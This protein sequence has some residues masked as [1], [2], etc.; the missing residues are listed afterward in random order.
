MAIRHVTDQPT[1]TQFSLVAVVGMCAAR[2][3]PP[4][5]PEIMS[6]LSKPFPIPILLV[7]VLLE[8]LEDRLA[9]WL[10]E[11]TG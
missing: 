1:E 2:G 4:A 11:T 9:K 8:E 7:Q 3:G 6:A 5:L 10:M